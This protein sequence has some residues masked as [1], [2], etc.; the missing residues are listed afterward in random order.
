VLLQ[1]AQIGVLAGGARAHDP[2]AKPKLFEAG[3][4]SGFRLAGGRGHL[5]DRA[6]DVAARDLA[7]ALQMFVE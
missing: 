7:I 1:R 6:L 4:L 2:L 5:P 3:P